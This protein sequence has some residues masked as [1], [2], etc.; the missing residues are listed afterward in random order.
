MNGDTDSE[1]APRA[2]V[3]SELLCFVVNRGRGRFLSFDDIVQ[4]CS[5]F[6]TEDEVLTARKQLED[7]GHQMTKCSGD[8][9]VKKTMQDI[10]KLVLNPN[11]EF[12]AFGAANLSRLPPMNAPRRDLPSLLARIQA[13][14]LRAEACNSGTEITEELDQLEAKCRSLRQP[15]PVDSS[16]PQQDE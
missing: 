5:D 3:I 1:T 8:D 13:V 7:L 15:Q 10:V 11:L 12:P 16:D 9:V 2:V 14:R 6:Y 4:I